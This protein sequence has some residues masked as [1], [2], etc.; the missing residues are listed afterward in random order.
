MEISKDIIKINQLLKQ[1]YDFEEVFENTSNL[2][3]L[4]QLENTIMQHLDQTVHL[5][6]FVQTQNFG[7]V[8][9][10]L[11]VIIGAKY[12]MQHKHLLNLHF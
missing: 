6:L 12:G 1:I 5:H 7:L 3:L 4:V 10:T 9:I 11:A 2:E 8:Q